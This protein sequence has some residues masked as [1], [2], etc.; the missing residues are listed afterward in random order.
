MI[1]D[2]TRGKLV[3]TPAEEPHLHLQAVRAFL[4]AVPRHGY[5][6]VHSPV[7]LTCRDGMI[8]CN[9]KS[10]H[11]PG[12]R[13]LFPLNAAAGLIFAA[14]I[15]HLRSREQIAQ[16]MSPTRPSPAAFGLEPQGPRGATVSLVGVACAPARWSV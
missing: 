13:F 12:V 6:R 1:E 3:T 16:V 8:I 5:G 15:Y 10:H 7:P 11:E 4:K 9:R 2:M 14:E